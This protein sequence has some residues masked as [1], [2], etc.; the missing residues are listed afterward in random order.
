MK[1]VYLVLLTIYALIF[2]YLAY[3]EKQPTIL[4]GGVTNEKLP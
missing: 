3:P 2:I 4:K 1:I